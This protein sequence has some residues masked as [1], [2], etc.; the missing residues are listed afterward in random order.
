MFSIVFGI[1][2]VESLSKILGQPS[3]PIFGLP[4]SSSFTIGVFG[5]K[6]V[7]ECVNTH[8]LP[9]MYRLPAQFDLVA[10][11][12]RKGGSPKTGTQ[13]PLVHPHGLPPVYP[14]G[15]HSKMSFFGE[16]TEF[17]ALERFWEAGSAPIRSAL[18]FYFGIDVRIF[19]QLF[20]KNIFFRT[21]NF[22]WKIDN[23]RQK[24]KKNQKNRNF[25][26]SKI[27]NFKIL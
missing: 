22:F 4:S 18:K 3:W 9:P 17:H 21:S 20:L 1:H 25:K 26:I 10:E 27:D 16:P 11:I 7:P 23:S 13:T 15:L 24:L 2:R 6:P 19:S 14:H 5:P 12:S 8:L